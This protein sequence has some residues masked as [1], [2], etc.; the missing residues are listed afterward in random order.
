MFGVLAFLNSCVLFSSIS[1]KNCQ[2]FFA[3]HSDS[4]IEHLSNTWQLDTWRLV[5]CPT[6]ALCNT[7]KIGCAHSALHQLP[8]LCW[9]IISVI[10]NTVWCIPSNLCCLSR[11]PSLQIM[12]C[13]TWKKYIICTAPSTQMPLQTHPFPLNKITCCSATPSLALLKNCWGTTPSVR[14][15]KHAK[16]KSGCYKPS[17]PWKQIMKQEKEAW[18]TA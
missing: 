4:E 2:Y 7:G 14:E 5:S 16:Y 3:F 11:F 8:P 18:Q 1:W 17:T 9:L 13:A 15:E 10:S 12:Q 6:E